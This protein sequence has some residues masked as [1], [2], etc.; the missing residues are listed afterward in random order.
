MNFDL[1]GARKEGSNRPWDSVYVMSRCTHPHRPRCEIH[2]IHAPPRGMACVSP[3]SFLRFRDAPL[4]QDPAW[5]VPV[6]PA[7]NAEIG[8]VG[9]LSRLR[10]QMLGRAGGGGCDTGE[11]GARSSERL[12]LAAAAAQFHGMDH[13]S[14]HAIGHVRVFRKGEP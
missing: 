3:A 6:W 4:G 1:T 14:G 10:L 7:S 5:R 9:V 8:E 13:G 2:C 11:R 12:R